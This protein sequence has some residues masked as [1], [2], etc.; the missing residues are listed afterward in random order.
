MN[1]ITF[2]KGGITVTVEVRDVVDDI[3]NKLFLITPLVSGDNQ[4]SGP[5]DVKV[6]DLLRI[7]NSYQ[8]NGYISGTTTP[9]TLTAKQVKDNLKLIAK[10]ANTAS[11][12]VTMVYDGDSITG[13]IEKLRFTEVACDE[14]DTV[15]TDFAKYQVTL[16]FTVGIA[17]G[18]S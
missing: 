10:G 11:S 12:V 15:G 16:T 1:E 18:S 3:S 14:P 8:I 13:Y 7:T 5:K 2:S 17:V 9:T 6:I 4:A